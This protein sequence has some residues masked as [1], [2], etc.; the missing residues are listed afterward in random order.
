MKRFI[1]CLMT[2]S[3]LFAGWGGTAMSE[4]LI[5]NGGFEEGDL[6]G[7]VPFFGCSAW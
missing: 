5:T 1:G 6:T 4:E 7:W 2:L 3:F